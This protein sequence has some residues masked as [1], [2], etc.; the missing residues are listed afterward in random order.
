MSGYV[1]GLIR[2]RS[3]ESSW[4]SVINRKATSLASVY[5]DVGDLYDFIPRITPTFAPPR[6]LDPL[7][8]AIER[9]KSAA[10]G[11]T[12]PVFVCSSVPPQHAKTETY[13]HGFAYWLH[14][15][16]TDLLAYLSYNSEQAER[17]SSKVRDYAR[18]AGVQIRDDTHSRK[19]WRTTQGGG[20]LA[21]GLTGGSIT[22]QDA[23]KAILIDDPFKDATQANSRVHREKA[24]EALTSSVWTRLH[25][26]TS[27]FINH[28]RWHVDDLIGRVK[29]DRKLKD[30]FEFINLP[31]VNPDGSVLWP[32]VMGP[33]LIQLKRDGSTDY[34]WW[35]LYMGE[36]RPRDTQ[37]FRDVSFYTELPSYYRLAIGVDLAYTSKKSSDWSVA[38][39]MAESNGHYYVVDVV[40]RQVSA[41]DFADELKRLSKRYPA[42]SMTGYVSGTEQGTIDFMR[43]EGVP[44]VGKP[45]TQDKMVRATPFSAA[46]N[47]GKVSVPQEHAPWVEPFTACLLDFTGLDDPQDDDVDAGSS[48]FDALDSGGGGVYVPDDSAPRRPTRTGMRG[49][50]RSTW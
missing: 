36:P 23:L 43:R 6:H 16:P 18:I 20:L 48:A 41:P 24:W 26:T 42:A 28:T 14:E 38:V 5:I 49:R 46:W 12:K 45:A 37:L 21:G 50:S 13:L 1:S 31:A 30:R 33:E 15:Q 22:G 40:R 8:D 4:R 25:E 19:F 35:S 11:E 7:V 10:R 27:V 44:I 9:A 32:E 29:A 34:Q 3:E 47:A 17:K 2:Q 39:V